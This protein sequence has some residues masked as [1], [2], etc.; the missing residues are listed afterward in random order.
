MS[1]CKTQNKIK[2]VGGSV[3]LKKDPLER[4]APVFFV[5]KFFRPDEPSQAPSWTIWRR[6]GSH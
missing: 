2:M 6:D 1:V 5:G 3:L 4:G